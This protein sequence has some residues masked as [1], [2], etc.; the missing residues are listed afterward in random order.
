MPEYFATAFYSSKDYGASFGAV[1]LG[2]LQRD[3]HAEGECE[4]MEIF[5]MVRS[6]YNKDWQY[7]YFLCGVIVHK[8][9]VHSGCYEVY[10]RD[11]YDQVDGDLDDMI[12]GDKWYKFNGNSVYLL[13][14]ID[15]I[16]REFGDFN[17]RWNSCAYM[18]M[19]RSVGYHMSHKIE[20]NVSADL[21]QYVSDHDSK[22]NL[23]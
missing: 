10:L 23:D 1:D 22:Q 8:G 2:I 6:D 16:A 19:Y 15:C 13:E 14:S 20:T 17:N 9:G 7:L 21:K 4:D 3:Y 18:L 12:Y 11:I 5:R